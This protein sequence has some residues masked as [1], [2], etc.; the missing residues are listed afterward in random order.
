MNNN[1]TDGTHDYLS[2]RSVSNSN[3]PERIIINLDVNTGGAGGFYVGMK[4]ALDTNADW[5][6]VSDDDAYPDKYALLHILQYAE[7]HSK[8]AACICGAVYT[9]DAIDIDHRRISKN[10][11][12]K[13]PYKLPKDCYNKQEVLIEETTFVG[14]CFN[15]EAVRKAGLPLKEFFIY[16]DDTEYSYRIGHYGNIV[17][18]PDI[19]IT[20]DT[21][22]Y[23]QPTNIIV[24]W[25]DYYLIRNH[26]Y[27]LRCHHLPSFFAYCLKK[28]YDSL[29]TYT[30]KHNAKQLKMYC[31]AIL[32][33]ITGHL[34]L[35]PIYKP[36]YNI[37][38]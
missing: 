11:F 6:W 9:N 17:L 31:L 21:I 20:H 37:P 34:G 36:G 23:A 19:K 38:A 16:F 8:D 4:R 2:Q 1:S 28:I 5:I 10:R 29:I 32:H 27:T 25:R 13:L 26:I 3:I 14:S 12:I 22:T 30:R 15:A 33:G 7:N 18:L 24:T 35:H